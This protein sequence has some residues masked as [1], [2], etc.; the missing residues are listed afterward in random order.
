MFYSEACS[1]ASVDA[2]GKEQIVV[3]K[4][5]VHVILLRRA[6]VRKLKAGTPPQ[7]VKSGSVEPGRRAGPVRGP[8]V[9]ATATVVSR[10]P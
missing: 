1:S 3:G 5:N 8:K 9:R 6:F 2:N 7:D 4:P 10:R